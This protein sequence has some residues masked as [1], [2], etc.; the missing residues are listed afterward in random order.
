MDNTPHATDSTPDLA[1][2]IAQFD[3]DAY[4]ADTRTACDP[5]FFD[6][7]GW[8]VSPATVCD[9]QGFTIQ[10]YETAA[11]D[12]NVSNEPDAKELGIQ[13]IRKAYAMRRWLMHAQPDG[14][15]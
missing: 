10:D 8:S 11:E 4:L 6:T 2:A 7:S 14:K 3:P 15:N 5:S 12:F 1:T 9:E 13:A